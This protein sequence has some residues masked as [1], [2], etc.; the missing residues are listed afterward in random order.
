M[1]RTVLAVVFDLDGT[2]LDTARD[3][4]AGVNQAL[5]RFSLPEHSVEEYHARIGHG[6]R[7]LIAAAVQEDTPAAVREEILRDYLAY[8][9]E[10]C[11]EKTVLYPGAAELVGGLVRDGFRTAVL[12]NKTEPTARRIISRFF[13]DTPFAFVWGNNGAR[14]LKPA[15]DAGY[16]ILRELELRPEQIAFVGD[17]ETD[18]QFAAQL[19]FRA[20]GVSWGYRSRQ[21]LWDSG[22]QFVAESACEAGEYLRAL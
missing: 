15:L 8:Y 20:V 2:L 4:G 3:I 17:G 21:T 16:A 5:R 13:P 10:H 19:G 18:M 22:A 1:G 9:P 6:I 11:T 14:P 12:S 7:D